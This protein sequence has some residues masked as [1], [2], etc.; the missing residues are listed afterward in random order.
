MAR[1]VFYYHLKRLKSPDKYAHIKELIK[2]IFDEHKGRYGVR[3]ITAEL[4]HR[5]FIINHKVVERLMSC[6]DLKCLIRKVKYRSYKGQVGK[7]APNVIER[8]F[9]AAAPNL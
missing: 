1:S 7:V 3:R 8:N 4:K 2:S 6:L 5:G 9:S